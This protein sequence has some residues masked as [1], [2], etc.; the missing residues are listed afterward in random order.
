MAPHINGNYFKYATIDNVLGR[1]VEIGRERGRVPVEYSHLKHFFLLEYSRSSLETFSEG[2]IFAFHLYT[3]ILMAIALISY[4]LSSFKYG[5]IPLLPQTL[6]R[7]KPVVGKPPINFR[8]G[9]LP[10][11]DEKEVV[12][13]HPHCQKLKDAGDFGQA[14]SGP[15]SQAPTPREQR[16]LAITKWLR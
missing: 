5:P 9:Q 15:C 13:L 7:T 6:S 1:K 2:D 16:K 12:C 14:L 8:S 11:K 10:S 4:V 3:I